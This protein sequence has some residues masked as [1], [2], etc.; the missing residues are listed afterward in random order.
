VSRATLSWTDDTGAVRLPVEATTLHAFAAALHAALLG[1]AMVRVFEITLQYYNDREQFG[2]SL[3]KFQAIQHML[4]VMAEDTTASTLAAE[5]AFRTDMATPSLLPA[6]MAKSRTSG[7]GV[8]ASCR[9]A[10]RLI[11]LQS[12]F[13]VTVLALHGHWSG[14]RNAIEFRRERRVIFGRLAAM[15]SRFSF[16]VH[17]ST[18]AWRKSRSDSFLVWND[19]FAKL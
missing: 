13:L 14:I 7:A 12:E 16:S 5:S 2:R 8:N 18:G 3:G 15:Q 9:A 6:A 1:G 17:R 11:W 19:R 10:P 4:T